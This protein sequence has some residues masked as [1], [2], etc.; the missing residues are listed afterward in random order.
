M[1]KAANVTKGFNVISKQRRQI[2]EEVDKLFV[3]FIKEK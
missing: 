1:I 3:M 2:I